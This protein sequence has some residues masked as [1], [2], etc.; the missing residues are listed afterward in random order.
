MSDWLGYLVVISYML[1]YYLIYLKDKVHRQEIEKIHE[2][3]QEE[4][5]ELLDRIMANNIHEFKSVTGSSSIKRSETGNFLKDRMTQE[6]L[7]HFT[8]LD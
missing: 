4:R 5:Q 6:V 1:S 2:T 3:Y 8:E 7:K